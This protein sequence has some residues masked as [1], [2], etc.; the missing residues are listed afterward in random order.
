MDIT[1]PGLLIQMVHNTNSSS[2]LVNIPVL[3]YLFC[4][5]YCKVFESLRTDIKIPKACPLAEFPL[6]L[7]MFILIVSHILKLL[8]GLCQLLRTSVPRIRGR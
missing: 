7:L 3:S 8:L 4:S 2:S 1:R 6:N 5:R